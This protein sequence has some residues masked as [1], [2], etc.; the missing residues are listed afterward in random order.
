MAKKE[1]IN[2]YLL[3]DPDTLIP[4]DRKEFYEEQIEQFQKEG[5][6]TRACDVVNIFIFNSEGELLI[7]KR[8]ETKNHNPSMFDKTIG[9]H[10][11]YGDTF[12]YTVMVETVQ[13]IQTPSIVLKNETDFKKTLLLL[14]DYTETI[15]II[16]HNGTEINCLEKIIKGEKIAIAN[17]VHLYFGLYDGRTRPVDKEAQG[18]IYYKLEN[19]K[20]EMKATPDI[21]T[22]DLH[23][24]I[25]KY[26]KEIEAFIKRIKKNEIS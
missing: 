1:I 14:S 15:S 2:T 26:E 12:D 13:E 8:S 20:K 18:V 7:Q 9:G 17:K 24:F 4:M 19:L 22:A 21:F 6:P 5:K 25:E 11:V 23:F 16:K 10:V 3:D